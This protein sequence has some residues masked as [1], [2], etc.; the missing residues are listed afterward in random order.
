MYD[1]MEKDIKSLM[2]KVQMLEAELKEKELHREEEQI[3]KI[4]E[5][6]KVDI[7]TEENNQL[8]KQL[9]FHIA[10]NKNGKDKIIPLIEEVLKYYGKRIS[11]KTN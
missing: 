3:Y 8:K 5:R 4:S 6:K 7:L 9:G 10:F 1:P 11:D 2:Q